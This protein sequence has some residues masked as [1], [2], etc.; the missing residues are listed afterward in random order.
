M[1]S[2]LWAWLAVLLVA[3]GLGVRATWR[4]VRGP[5]LKILIVCG[6]IGLLVLA[7]WVSAMIYNIAN[8]GH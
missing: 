8:G 6:G 3:F 1:E 4:S 5:A 7:S 2:L